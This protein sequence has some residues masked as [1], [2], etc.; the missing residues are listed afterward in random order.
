MADDEETTMTDLLEQA[1]AEHHLIAAWEQ[2]RDKAIQRGGLSPAHK[3]FQ[4]KIAGSIATISADLRTGTWTPDPVHRVQM[5]KKSGGHRTLE[6]PSVRDR[7]VERSILEV[8]D[9]VIDPLLLPWV[10]G[11]RRGL[12]VNDAIA[13]VIEARDEGA[14][15]AVKADIARCFDSIPTARV[16]ELLEEKCNLGELLCTIEAIV[17]RPGSRSRFSGKGLHQGSPLAPLLANIYLDQLD[18]LLL[19]KGV[20]A[21]RYGDDLVIPTKSRSEA[22]SS[23]KTLQN[24]AGTLE[25]SLG[26][27]STVYRYSDGVPYLGC[28]ITETSSHTRTRKGT[29]QCASV[30]VAESSGGLLRSRGN[31]LVLERG[32]ERVFSIGFARVGQV[33]VFGRVGFTTPFL[34]RVMR[35]G[36]EVV[37]LDEHG[38]YAGRLQ[39]PVGSNP[40]ARQAQYAA[41]GTGNGLRLAKQ[42]VTGKLVNQRNLLLKA[43]RSRP[44]DRLRRA[45]DRMEGSI[46]SVAK[47]QS[48]QSLLGVE[49]AAGRE[50]FRAFGENLTGFSFLKRQMRPPPDPINALLSFGYTLVTNELVGACET[51]GLDPYMGLLHS[52]RPTRPSLALDLIE[53]VRP[54]IVDSLVLGLVNRRRLSPDDF[55]VSSGPNPSCQLTS[56]GRKTFLKAYEHRMLT[57]FNHAGSGRNVTYRVGLKLQARALADDLLGR[58]PYRPIVWK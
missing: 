4:R 42:F 36:I 58:D 20:A 27:D 38:R 30:Y 13:T 15:Y 11:F 50:Y 47:Q 43:H 8:L 18:R 21:V 14:R 34:H 46:A 57:R 33:V 49:G 12:G 53:E 35:E 26:H 54:V 51:A 39:G 45:V 5:P 29:P 1:S 44:S 56:S 40:F 55:V 28:T 19:G 6:I 7:V 17:G 22:E 2:V 9:P 31:R 37:M 16:L 3:R 32:G 24:A 10:F 48:I 23:L 25:L 52:P 41:A